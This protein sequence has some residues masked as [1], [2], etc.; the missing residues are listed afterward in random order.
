MKP[1]EDEGKDRATAETVL[2]RIVVAVARQAEALQLV[3]HTQ[4]NFSARLPGTRLIVITPSGVPYAEMGPE[5]LVT[6]DLETGTV[7]GRHRP[8]S[9]LE[10][11]RLAYRSRPWVGGCAHVEP[12]YLNALYAVN[13]EVPNLLGNFV[14]LFAG[15]GLAV[16]PAL[17]SGTRE[18]AEAVLAAMGDRLGVVWKNHGLFCVGDTLRSAL[19]R[20]VAAEQAAKVYSLAL[21]LGAGE[22]APIPEEVQEEMVRTARALGLTGSV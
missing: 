7:A 18:F 11:H 14:Y 6:V 19:D 21:A 5:D 9:E 8:S 13:R 12:P 2:R 22:P 10:V 15:R 3:Q 16:A 4:G 17:R 1:P 20:C